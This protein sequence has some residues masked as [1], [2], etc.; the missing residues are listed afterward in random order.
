MVPI[1]RVISIGCNRDP[2]GM[3]GSCTA[4]SHTHTDAIISKQMHGLCI[5]TNEDIFDYFF[6]FEELD[7]DLGLKK[8]GPFE[9]ATDKK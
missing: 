4:I 9:N 8:F 6:I 7:T 1:I 3:R 2:N 5:F